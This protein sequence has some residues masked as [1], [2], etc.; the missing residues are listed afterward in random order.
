MGCGASLPAVPGNVLSLLDSAG[1]VLLEQVTAVGTY[2]HDCENQND[3]HFVT[4][5]AEG[6]QLRWSNRAGV[7]WSLTPRADGDL[8]VG[9]ECPYYSNGYTVCK[10]V[11]NAAGSVTSLL[12]PSGEPYD[13]Q[14]TPDPV[15]TTAT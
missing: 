7:S 13:L 5:T 11:R 9:E 2:E 1:K 10:V 6:L 15:L 3:Y 8:D 4:V 14:A 12:G